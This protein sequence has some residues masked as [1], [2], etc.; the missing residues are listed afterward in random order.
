MEGAAH[1]GSVSIDSEAQE[2]TGHVTIRVTDT[3]PGFTP[4]QLEKYN[5]PLNGGCHGEFLRANFTCTASTAKK[6]VQ[7]GMQSS[8]KDGAAKPIQ[9]GAV[10]PKRGCSQAKRRVQPSQKEGAVKPKGGCSQA[11]RRVQ[12]SQMEGA[13][14]PNGG[15]SQTKRRVQ[16]NQEGRVPRGVFLVPSNN[17]KACSTDAP[18]PSKQRGRSSRL[19]WAIAHD[20]RGLNN[21]P[22]DGP[23]TSVH[24]PLST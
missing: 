7:N 1:A 8:P 24:P 13:A 9:E 3:G 6:L 22:H 4:E 16:P 2:G 18:G 14:K 12:S 20:S 11:K 15:C 10:K 23:L 21:R 19:A 5:A 17:R